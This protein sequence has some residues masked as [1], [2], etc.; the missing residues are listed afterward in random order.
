MHYLNIRKLSAARVRG[1]NRTKINSGLAFFAWKT[2]K[3]EKNAHN[4]VFLKG[5]QTKGLEG[6]GPSRRPFNLPKT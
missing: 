1:G 2:Q 5:Q 3:S 6:V 4:S